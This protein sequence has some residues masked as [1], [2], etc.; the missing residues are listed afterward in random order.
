MSFLLML[1]ALVTAYPVLL[2][3]VSAPSFTRLLLAELWLSFLFGGYN[4]AMVVY[5]V[6]V[7]PPQA[8]TAGFSRWDLRRGFDGEPYTSHTQEMVWTAWKD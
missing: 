3:L 2:W 1:L 8:R 7:M 4:G 5:L 6:E